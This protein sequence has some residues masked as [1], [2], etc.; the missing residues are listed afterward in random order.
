MGVKSLESYFHSSGDLYQ[1][2]LGSD[3]HFSFSDD[4]K[5]MRAR[6]F[7]WDKIKVTPGQNLFPWY[8]LKIWHRNESVESVLL[9]SERIFKSCAQAFRLSL[10]MRN[11]IT[12][13]AEDRQ[14]QPPALFKVRRLALMLRPSFALDCHYTLHI[15]IVDSWYLLIGGYRRSERLGPNIGRQGR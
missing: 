3:A 9:I 11:R 10:R 12:T 15:A 1:A 7:V 4:H 13:L 14:F 2:S 5:A 6:G 8:D